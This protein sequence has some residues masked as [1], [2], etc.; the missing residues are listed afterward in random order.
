MTPARS[1]RCGLDRFEIMGV[2]GETVVR[3][4]KLADGGYYGGMAREFGEP[5]LDADLQ[6]YSP[7]TVCD[8]GHVLN[9]LTRLAASP[10][11][12]ELWELRRYGPLGN[13]SA[14]IARQMRAYDL[15]RCLDVSEQQ[16]RDHF[17]QTVTLA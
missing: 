13:H 15:A 1:C 6:L 8:L 3:F 10:S 17:A 4:I 7:H 12:Y 2:N 11:R 5:D 14:R 16:V 9:L